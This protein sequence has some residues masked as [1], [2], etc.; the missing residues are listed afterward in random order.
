MYRICRIWTYIY[1]FAITVTNIIITS[2]S[3]PVPL[4]LCVCV[5]RSEIVKLLEEGRNAHFLSY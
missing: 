3:F 4:S 1:T 2:K 5:L